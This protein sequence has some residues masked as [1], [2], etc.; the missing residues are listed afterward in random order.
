VPVERAT[1]QGWLVWTIA[2]VIYFAA[3]FHRCSLGVASLEAGERFGVGPA[4]LG[5]FTVLQ[6]GVYAAMQ[7]PTGLLVDRFGPR[8]MLT[9][10]ALLMGLGQVLFAVADSYSLGLVART[11]LGVGDALTFVSVLRLVAAHFPAHRYALVV[12]LTG[13]FGSAGNLVATVPLTLML[14]G[15]GW[16]VT[17]LVAGVATTLYSALIMLRLRD[18]PAGVTPP[19]VEPVRPR[20]VVNKVRASWGTPGTRL[21]FW[22]H[23]ATTAGPATLGLLWGFP[24]LVE[25][26]GLS[27]ATAGTMLG[28]LVLG[29]LVGGPLVGAF[30]ARRPELRTPLTVLFLVSSLV[31]WAV[32]L[33]WPGGRPPLPVLVLAFGVLSLGGPV[34]AVGFALARD[35]N[36]LQRVGTATGVVNVGG[37]V[38]TTIAALTTGVLLDLTAALAPAQSFRIALLA[39]V[40]VVLFGTVRALVWWRRARAAVFAAEARGEEVPVRLRP[41]RWDIVPAGHPALAAA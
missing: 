15:I 25:G 13:V 19:P 4:A 21:G 27:Q 29:G 31:L 38:A 34:S 33:A 26:Q 10:A 18:F 11:V 22:V 16:T 36:P 37:F 9:G 30:T 6:V 28:V 7:V 14:D 17:F 2:V 41:S 8:L 3:V 12:A 40:G 32:L 23:F 39:L 5:V 1:R 24:Y 20:E 35:Y